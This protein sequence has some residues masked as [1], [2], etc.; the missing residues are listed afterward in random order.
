[1]YLIEHLWL[2]EVLGTHGHGCRDGNLYDL[3][4]SD[5]QKLHCPQFI[6]HL[7]FREKACSPLLISFHQPTPLAA[8]LVSLA[9]LPLTVVSRRQNVQAFQKVI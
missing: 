3:L 9:L 6:A 4:H 2:V 1:M 8:S 5:Q 7:F